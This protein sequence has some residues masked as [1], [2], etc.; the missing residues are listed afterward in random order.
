MPRFGSQFSGWLRGCCLKA[1]WSNL[2]RAMAENT[3][4]VI[5]VTEFGAVR[6]DAAA[7]PKKVLQQPTCPESGQEID[8]TYQE[9]QILHS[10]SKGLTR[11][12]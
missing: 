7:H 5:S 2:L 3:A 11:D 4:L 8:P 9:F 12:C 10:A 1:L 6:P